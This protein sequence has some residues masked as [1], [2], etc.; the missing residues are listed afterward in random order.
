MSQLPYTS[1]MC[2]NSFS[3][4]RPTCLHESSNE[5]VT[6]IEVANVKAHRCNNCSSFE[7]LAFRPFLDVV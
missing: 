6:W 1:T 3:Q 5:I 2:I 7:A 4:A